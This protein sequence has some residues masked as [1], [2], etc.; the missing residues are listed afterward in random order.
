MLHT[1]QND[2]VTGDIGNIKIAQVYSLH[3]VC[4]ITLFQIIGMA[5]EGKG[6]HL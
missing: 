3:D 4:R 2:I 5:M 6:K 1:D